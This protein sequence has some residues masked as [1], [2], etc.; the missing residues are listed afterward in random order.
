MYTVDPTHDHEVEFLMPPTQGEPAK[1]YVVFRN[2]P[3]GAALKY[4]KADF[5][6]TLRLLDA[7]RG[8]ASAS[9]RLSR[10]RPALADCV[11]TQSPSLQPLLN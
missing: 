11:A 2:S 3:G 9:C 4:V 1:Y 5:S 7:D 6:L 8:A 10:G